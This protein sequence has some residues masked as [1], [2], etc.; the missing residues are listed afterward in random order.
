VRGK[1]LTEISLYEDIEL[2]FLEKLEENCLGKTGNIF[3]MCSQYF[4]KM[5]LV[6]CNHP[7][8]ILATVQGEMSTTRRYHHVRNA[9]ARISVV[10]KSVVVLERNSKLLRQRN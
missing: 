6:L 7:K 5:P 1:I 10:A 8:A 3:L 2:H 9:S 4:I